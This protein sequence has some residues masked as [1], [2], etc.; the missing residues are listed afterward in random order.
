M[1]LRK[2]ALGVGISESSLYFS[3]PP[4]SIK[5]ILE[6]NLDPNWTKYPIDTTRKPKKIDDL[7]KLDISR[8]LT[9]L[10]FKVP[11][12]YIKKINEEAQVD[13][14]EVEEENEEDEESFFEGFIVDKEKLKQIKDKL[15][16]IAQ[17]Q[18]ALVTEIHSTSKVINHSYE[19]DITHEEILTSEEMEVN[20]FLQWDTSDLLEEAERRWELTE[21]MILPSPIP[22]P[23][24]I[25]YDLN[26]LRK[27]QFST[28][29]MLGEENIEEEVHEEEEDREYSQNTGCGALLGA[30]FG[31]GICPESFT[32]SAD[33]FSGVPGNNVR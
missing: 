17:Q 3:F 13:S 33:R 7:P 16:I 14:P 11:T 15:V 28:P 12:E 23:N 30:R 27:N 21:A 9:R 8:I 29:M 26:N 2:G 31:R 19:T 18:V 4:E 25:S 20:S 22:E 24:I 5:V 6:L 10:T 32:G 1:E